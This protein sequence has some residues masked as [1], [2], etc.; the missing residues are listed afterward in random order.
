MRYSSVRLFSCLQR[1]LYR[2]EYSTQLYNDVKP[3][4]HCPVMASET[5]CYLKPS[6]G[7]LFIDMTFGAGGHTKHLLEFCP[8]LKIIALDRDPV[9]FGYAQKLAEQ[10]PNQITPLLGKF[11]ELPEL[12][13]QLSIGQ[14]SVDGILFDFG[15]SSMQFDVANRGFSLSKD[16]PLDMRMDGDR[17]PNSPTASDV[18]AVSDEE[19]LIK[20]FKVYGEEKLAKKIARAIVEARYTFKTFRS[21]RELADFISGVCDKEYRLDKMQRN[22]HIATK[23]FQAL[24]IFVNNEL[25]EINYA[26]IVAQKFLKVGGRL[27]TICFHSLEDTIVKRH[28]AGHTV[29]N[30]VSKIPQKYINYS[31][32]HNLEAV[33]EVM[34]SPWSMMNR[35]VITPTE[36][37]IS[38]NPRSRSAKLRAAV[39]L[40]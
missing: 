20:I 16:G 25:N 5:I 37:E 15:C 3:V 19:D 22:A 6:D 29:N 30:T 11:S 23:V 32:S 24:R 9:A 10:Y 14:N 7:D 18:L 39:K 35:N 33:E 31:K 8:S 4:P 12:L 27:V 1:L 26:M 28:I 2:R 38:V 36:D 17:F 21:T 34:S 40:R 13:S